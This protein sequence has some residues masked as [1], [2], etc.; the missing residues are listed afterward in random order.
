MVDTNWANPKKGYSMFL[1]QN[2]AY[3]RYVRA[4]VRVYLAVNPGG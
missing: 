1:D 4:T 3:M 2:T